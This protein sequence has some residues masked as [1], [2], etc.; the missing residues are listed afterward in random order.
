MSGVGCADARAQVTIA[1]MNR[2]VENAGCQQKCALALGNFAC[3]EDN[4][5]RCIPT[6]RA[7]VL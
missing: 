1:A 4:Q 2:F 3:Q 5:V 6:S 7:F